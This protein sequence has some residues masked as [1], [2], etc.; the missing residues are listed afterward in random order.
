M[1]D[2]GIPPPHCIYWS[3]EN[4]AGSVEKLP[5]PKA[6]IENNL[7][8]H[9]HDQVGG[10][11]IEAILAYLRGKKEVDPTHYPRYTEDDEGRLELILVCKT[12]HLDCK[13]FRHV[14]TFD[15][16][17]KCDEYN[18]P[19]VVLVGCNHTLKAVTFVCALVVHEDD[20]SFIW[21]SEQLVEAGD[22][23]NSKAVVADVNKS[24]AN[25]IKVV[26]LEASHKLWPWHLMRN[27][28]SNDS[29]FTSAF[30]KC[31]NKYRTPK[32]LKLV[33][34]NSC[35][36]MVYNI[37]S[38]QLTHIRIDRSE[39]KYIYMNISLISK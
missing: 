18:K 16:M 34:R 23:Q 13:T 9:M 24:M 3:M 5:Y 37:G 29:Q 15:N 38:G 7:Y 6:D 21:V 26:F 8:K 1:Y 30:I 4:R 17:Y 10:S 28:Q 22:G 11:D 25:V 33:S 32:D 12:S 2:V 19:L 39:Q 20:A 14:L 31:A 27:M 36:I 35:L